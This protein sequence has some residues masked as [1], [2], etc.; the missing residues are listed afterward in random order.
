[1]QAVFYTVSKRV[2]S[3]KQGTGGSTY[4]VTLKEG[5]SIIA[6]RLALIWPGSGNPCAYNQCYI[7]DF[8]RYY[9]VEDW[10]YIDRQ[11][12]ASCRVDVLASYKTEIGSA[13]KYILRAADDFDPDVLDNKYLSKMTY[14]TYESTITA[15]FG[16]SIANGFYVIAVSGSGNTGVDYFLLTP[17]ELKKV[18]QDCYTDTE[19]YWQNLPVAGSV[20]EALNNFGYASYY[21][22]SN[23]FQYIQSVMWFPASFGVESGNVPIVL[24]NIQT[25]GIGRRISA[26]TT[27]LYIN[28]ITLPTPTVTENWMKAA[29]YAKYQLYLPGFGNLDLDPALCW[30]IS[31]INV[32][33]T[34]DYISGNAVCRIEGFTTDNK[35]CNLGYV[36]GQI[37]VPIAIAAKTVDALRANRFSTVDQNALAIA[38]TSVISG[39][40]TSL[41][42]QPTDYWSSKV[43]AADNAWRA[44]A[45]V[46]Q[47]SGTAGGLNY[48]GVDGII[49]VIIFDVVDQDIPEYGRPLMKVDALGSHTGFLLCG[50]GDVAISGTDEESQQIAAYLMGG[51]FYE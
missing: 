21:A 51:F 41:V 7:S 28:N 14:T 50:D 16:S 38:L 27:S 22:A 32:K 48:L 44:A 20:E 1:M 12:V 31:T 46:L 11:W 29:P 33:V 17:S 2:N 19:A 42:T 18:I 30:N 26:P 10:T 8:G 47:Q 5:C 13:Q 4:T 25:S 45:G 23:P 49:R 40:L 24:G 34:F 9:W 15:P 3:T 35:Y 39:N 43:A 37:G 6:P 36:N